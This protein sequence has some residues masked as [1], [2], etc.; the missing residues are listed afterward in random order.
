MTAEELDEYYLETTGMIYED[1]KKT[2]KP[3]NDEEKKNMDYF[4]DSLF[5]EILYI[6]LYF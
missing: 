6:L 5:V 1:F 4:F 2:C 3:L